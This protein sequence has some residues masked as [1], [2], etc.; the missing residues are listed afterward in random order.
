[1]SFKDLPEVGQA[2]IIVG[3]AVLAGLVVSEIL[4]DGPAREARPS[5]RKKVSTKSSSKR[6]FIVE[7]LKPGQRTVS[8]SVVP[9][10]ELRKY[11]DHYYS[12]SKQRQYQYR[13]DLAKELT[14]IAQR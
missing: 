12:L 13:Q 9:E 8:Q 1:M 6:T 11:P 10:S 14:E 5:S 4:D 7:T 3:G 2:L